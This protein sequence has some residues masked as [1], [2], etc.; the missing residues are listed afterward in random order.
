MATGPDSLTEAQQT[1]RSITAGRADAARE[2]LNAAIDAMRAAA[3]QNAEEARRNREQQT[4][5]GA[6]RAQD[7][8]AQAQAELDALRAQIKEQQAAA[9]GGA[10]R[11]MRRRHRQPAQ[12]GGRHVLGGGRGGPGRR[13]FTRRAHGSHARGNPAINRQQFEEQ[14]ELRRKLAEGG[15][16]A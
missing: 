7:A 16:V 12:P 1:A 11:T 4:G 15:V 5:G 6:N 9:E 13:R 10:A 2:K 14:K 8:L 3:E